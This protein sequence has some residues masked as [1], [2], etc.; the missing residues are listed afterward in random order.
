MWGSGQTGWCE[1]SRTVSMGGSWTRHLSAEVSMG[2]RAWLPSLPA[3]PLP[4]PLGPAAHLLS[5]CSSSVP[6][7]QALGGPAA[8]RG[9]GCHP[10]TAGAAG[11]HRRV[12]VYR[13]APA[14]L[15]P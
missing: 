11:D 12:L 10:H 8:A 15:Y 9:A 7:L 4:R 1:P 13:P 3:L 5:L 14:A 2:L 6:A